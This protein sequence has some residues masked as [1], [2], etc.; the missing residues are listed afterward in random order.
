MARYTIRVPERIG[1]GELTLKA[2]LLWRKFDRIYTEFAFQAN[3]RGFEA[4]K[5]VPDLPITV[6]AQDEVRLPVLPAGT[7]A[8]AIAGPGGGPED[9]ER[10]NDYGIGLLL[11]AETKWAEW[12][13]RRV[14]A[15]APGRPDGTRNLARTAVKDGDVP[16]AYGWLRSAESLAPGD[17]Q[18]AW[19]WGVV[20][21]EDGRYE[22]AAAAY[23]RAL[24]DFPQDRA[25]WTNL[26][27]LLYLDGKFA[28][29]IEAMGRVLEIDPE[30]RV[31]HYH[32]M[33]AY[34]AVGRA[35]EAATEEE[36]YLIYQIDES[37]REATRTYLLEHPEDT[38]STQPLYRRPVHEWAPDGRQLGA[39]R[40]QPVASHEGRD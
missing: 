12:A 24:Q 7:V 8:P 39:Y 3:P 1:G 17:A 18:T 20:L 23:R 10:F 6:I 31:A 13:F 36:A 19:V 33:L 22:E 16:E 4:F 32:R 14:A 34:R 11:Q 40:N 37:A 26:G 30:D 27:R 2:R 38:R 9:W 15:L 25:A 28:A 5:D 35:E 29:S 21:Q